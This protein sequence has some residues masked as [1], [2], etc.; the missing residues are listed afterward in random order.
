LKLQRTAIGENAGFQHIPNGLMRAT[1]KGRQS[2]R[3]RKS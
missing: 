1:R 2:R 3:W